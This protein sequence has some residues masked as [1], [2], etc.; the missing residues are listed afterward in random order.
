MVE[1]QMSIFQMMIDKAMHRK[2]KITENLPAD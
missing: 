1:L 2:P